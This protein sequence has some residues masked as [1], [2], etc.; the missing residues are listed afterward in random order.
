MAHDDNTT[1][2]IAD[3]SWMHIRYT[4]S[5]HRHFPEVRGEGRS[6]ADAAAH[7]VNQLAMALDFAHGRERE[8]IETALADVRAFRS[9]R[10]SRLS[11]RFH[12]AVAASELANISSF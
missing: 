10:P 1:I 5:H 7:L 3:G 12:G 6:I 4:G 8:A 9:R 2:I 11:P